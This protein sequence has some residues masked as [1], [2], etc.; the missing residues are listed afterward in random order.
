MRDK[1]GNSAL[2]VAI[3]KSDPILVRRLIDFNVDVN[4]EPEFLE[5]QQTETDVE[6]AKKINIEASKEM[7]EL[8]NILNPLEKFVHD[9]IPSDASKVLKMVAREADRQEKIRKIV[10]AV[11]PPPRIFSNKSKRVALR[12]Q[13]AEERH[14]QIM[15]KYRAGIEE[16]M[17]RRD[18]K[19]ESEKARNY[20]KPEG[21]YDRIGPSRWVLR[22]PKTIH[23]MGSTKPLQP[24]KKRSK[25]RVSPED[26]SSN[27]DLSTE[28]RKAI[29]ES[30]KYGARNL[31]YELQVIDLDADAV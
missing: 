2:S 15:D 5:R 28:I 12:R 22:T 4:R 8:R 25:T 17:N 29:N 27:L 11:V 26:Y 3:R 21:K 7:D 16:D 9:L 13:Q 30:D 24:R 1:G 6:L 23:T 19:I 31:S 14:I 10:R 18:M 20:N